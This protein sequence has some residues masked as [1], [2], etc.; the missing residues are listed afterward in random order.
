MSKIEK[1]KVIR[2]LPVPVKKHRILQYLKYFV[3]G[4]IL[5][6]ILILLFR[7]VL[8]SVSIQLRQ[9]GNYVILQVLVGGIISM[10]V[11]AIQVG[12]FKQR[13]KSR[14]PLFVGLA[15]LGGA[16]GGGVAG[17]LLNSFMLSDAFSVGAIVG[18]LAGLIAGYT[19]NMLMSRERNTSAW[20]VYNAVSSAIIYAV[21]WQVGWGNDS[22]KF[23]A[24]AFL[25]MFGAGI[26]LVIYLNN[27]QR[28]LEFS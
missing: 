15:G 18:G 20:I 17:W 28:D 10:L 5:L 23:A 2:G 25:V 9:E 27:F 19:Q 6:A 8:A 22:G 14:Q 26:A 1:P 3:L 7:D 21:G 13:I 24:A 11:A 12:V 16:L 4:G